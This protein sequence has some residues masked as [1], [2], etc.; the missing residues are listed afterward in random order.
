MS[1]PTATPQ[2]I[3]QVADL[4]KRLDDLGV[5]ESW[6]ERLG[7]NATYRQ[8]DWDSERT[9]PGN[10][11]VNVHRNAQR[12]LV[13]VR[14]AVTDGASAVCWATAPEYLPADLEVLMRSRGVPLL[15][16]TDERRAFS[17]SSALL[18]GFPAERLVSIGITGTNAKTTTA[19]MLAACLQRAGIT[20]ALSSSRPARRAS[21]TSAW[22]TYHFRSASAP[23]SGPTTWRCTAP[24]LPTGAPSACSSTGFRPPGLPCTTPTSPTWSRWRRGPGHSTFRSAGPGTRW[25]CSRGAG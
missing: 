12:A 7:R 17:L 2:P 15:R 21:A 11:H 14:L 8:V 24:M 6:D 5:L 20:H 3:A 13:A 18:H 4:A 19:I 25:P 1:G 9:Q 10:L 23:R 16:V 22:S